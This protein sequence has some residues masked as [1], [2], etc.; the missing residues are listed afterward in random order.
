MES[1]L[2]NAIDSCAKLAIVIC[3]P[4]EERTQLLSLDEFGIPIF[5]FR[6]ED[7]TRHLPEYTEE[8]VEGVAWGSSVTETIFY[9]KGSKRGVQ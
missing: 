1:V 5:S 2:K 8:I 9:V 6:K 3:T 4:F 7:I